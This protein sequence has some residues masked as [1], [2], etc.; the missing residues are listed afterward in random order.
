M[1]CK[2]VVHMNH[3]QPR[4]RICNKPAPHMD[5]NGNVLCVKHFKKWFKKVYKM[6]YD[7]F[8]VESER[9]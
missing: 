1:R 7:D 6:E 5:D 2:R 8:K 4:K 9:D 3:C